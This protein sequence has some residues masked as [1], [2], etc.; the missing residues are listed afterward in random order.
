MLW[1][2]EPASSAALATDGIE[3]EINSTTGELLLTAAVTALEAEHQLILIA[4]DDSSTRM[5]TLFVVVVAAEAKPRLK[6]SL[7]RSRRLGRERDDC[8][9]HPRAHRS[10]PPSGLGREHCRPLMISRGAGT[11]ASVSFQITIEHRRGDDALGLRRQRSRWSMSNN[12]F[13]SEYRALMELFGLQIA[14]LGLMK[15][16]DVSPVYRAFDQRR[17]Q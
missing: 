9:P 1:S 12:E 2:L 11:I 5:E 3:A 14:S 15:G 13:E 7:T 8:Q 4:K 6:L 16:D 17:S 10:L